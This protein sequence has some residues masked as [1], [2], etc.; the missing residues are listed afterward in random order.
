MA[1]TSPQSTATDERTCSSMKSSGE[2]A[3]AA[4]IMGSSKVTTVATN[5]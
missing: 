5:P 2:L 1:L 4:N 3:V